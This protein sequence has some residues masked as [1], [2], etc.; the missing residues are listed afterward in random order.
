MSFLL[1][2]L[3]TVFGVLL[4]LLSFAG[5]AFGL[6]MAADPRTREPGVF[7]AVWWVPAVATAGGILMRDPVT[8]AIGAVCFVI[9]GLAFALERRGARRPARSRRTSS[10]SVEKSPPPESAKHWLSEA[11][12]RRP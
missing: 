11:A 1:T 2:F 6:Y 9:A 3:L 12:K 8:F 7:F 4:L 10:K 5:V